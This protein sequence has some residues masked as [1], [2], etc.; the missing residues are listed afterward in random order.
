[1]KNELAKDARVWEIKFQLFHF[2]LSGFFE[3]DFK[4]RSEGDLRE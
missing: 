3:E 4:V 2:P 1:M